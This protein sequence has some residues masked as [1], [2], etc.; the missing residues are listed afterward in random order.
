MQTPLKTKRSARAA[1]AI[2]IRL[3]AEQLGVKATIYVCEAQI[4]RSFFVSLL[5]QRANRACMLLGMCSGVFRGGEKIYERVSLS[6][7]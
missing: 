3:I 7:L 6:V 4:V 2:K 5:H 1:I